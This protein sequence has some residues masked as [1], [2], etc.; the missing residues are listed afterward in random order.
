MAAYTEHPEEAYLLCQFCAEHLS[1]NGYLSGAGL[2]CW[3]VELT[4]EEKEAIAPITRQIVEATDQA[5]SFLLWCNTALEG[6]DSDLIMNE[7]L[8]LLQGEIDGETFAEDMEVIY[9]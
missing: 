5:S 2:P 9:E 6:E 7:T 1:K 4:D 3:K 8:L